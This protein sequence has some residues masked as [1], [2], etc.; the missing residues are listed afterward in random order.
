MYK[1]LQYKNKKYFC[2]CNSGQV[3]NCDKQPSEIRNILQPRTHGVIFRTGVHPRL[4]ITIYLL[5]FTSD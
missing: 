5:Q 4:I 3:G 1:T 2:Y